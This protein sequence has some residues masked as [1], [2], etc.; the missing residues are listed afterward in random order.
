VR[1]LISLEN[2]SSDRRGENA[3]RERL[4]F[5]NRRSRRG[6]I[7][8]TVRPDLHALQAFDPRFLHGGQNCDV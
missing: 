6:N 1:P 8:L 4:E 3:L 5:R 7:Q 2:C